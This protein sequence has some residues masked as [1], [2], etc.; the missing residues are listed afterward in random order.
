VS[1]PASYRRKPVSILF[2]CA[3]GAL[4]S[5]LRRNDEQASAARRARVLSKSIR[6]H[7]SRRAFGPPQDE[8]SPRRGR[9]AE[10]RKPM[11]TTSVAGGGGRLSARHVRRLADTGPRF[12]RECPALPPTDAG[13][14]HVEGPLI[15]LT[16]ISQLLA[17]LRSEP[18]RSPGA[19]RVARC[20]RA[21]RA[22]RPSRFRN[23][24]RQRPSKGR[25][26][27]MISEV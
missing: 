2:V 23:A 26:G 3:F 20:E 13:Q 22:P 25:G 4:D 11:V 17:G 9:R 16:V 21:P 10:R 27:A 1:P 12:C 19:A 5:G 7:P 18:G 14:N 15:G 6:S 24:S 8:V